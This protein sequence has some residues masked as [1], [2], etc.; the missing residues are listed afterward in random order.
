[1]GIWLADRDMI[2]TELGDLF[3]KISRTTNPPR[4]NDFFKV[5]TPCISEEEN[6]ILV[7]NPT[8]EEIKNILW[9]MQPWTSPGPD[10]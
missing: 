7:T 6:D 9:Q 5:L 8:D 2:V 10:G 4:C 1:M 3:G